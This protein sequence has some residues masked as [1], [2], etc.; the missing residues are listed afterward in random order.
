M[1]QTL[2]LIFL[3]SMTLFDGLSGFNYKRICPNVTTSNTPNNYTFEGYFY[4]ILGYKGDKPN[5][6]GTT[7]K[8]LIEPICLDVVLKI[9]Q[10]SSGEFSISTSTPCERKVA[11]GV[12]PKSTNLPWPHFE[13][14]QNAEV[15]KLERLWIHDDLAIFWSC[16]QD[17]ETE[18]HDE[19]LLLAMRGKRY[20]FNKSR[21]EFLEKIIRKYLYG[22][23]LVRLTSL[24]YGAFSCPSNSTDACLLEKRKENLRFIFICFVSVLVVVLAIL[25]IFSS[26]GNRVGLINE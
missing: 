10:T 14:V 4:S 13:C 8:I 19:G 5:I 1:S 26:S 17:R 11:Y 15:T 22:S 25:V 7:T 18:T 2:V 21:E 20:H 12:I 24:E 9:Y 3:C 6:F 16:C 23:N